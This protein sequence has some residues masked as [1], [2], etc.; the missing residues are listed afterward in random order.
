MTPSQA[1]IS[2]WFDSRCP[3][4]VREI[5][6]MRRLDWLNRV[7]FVDIYAAESCP[8]DTELLLTRFHAKEPGRPIVSGAEAFAALWRHLPLLKLFG[9]LARAPFVLRCLEAAYAKFLTHRPKLQRLFK[10]QRKADYANRRGN[11]NY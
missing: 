2:V 6:V 8:L 9:E 11:S 3:L 4:C 1:R 5:A 7:T 10:W